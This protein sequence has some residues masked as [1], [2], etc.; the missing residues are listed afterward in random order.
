MTHPSRNPTPPPRLLRL[1]E[2]IAR[3]GLSRASIYRLIQQSDFPAPKRIGAASRW[4]ED[5][6]SAWIYARE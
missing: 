3:V 1:P 4:R 2:V 6:V 5:E